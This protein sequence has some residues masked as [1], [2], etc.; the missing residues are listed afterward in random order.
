[1]F[2]CIFTEAPDGAFSLC[3]AGKSLRHGQITE[4][5][6]LTESTDAGPNGSSFGLSR[7]FLACLELDGES[8]GLLLGTHVFIMTAI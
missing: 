5:T 7:S 4:R 2:F 6:K 8:V 3:F 1:M